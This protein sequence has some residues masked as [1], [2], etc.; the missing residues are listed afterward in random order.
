MLLDNG[1]SPNEAD[2]EGVTPAL[3]AKAKVRD[4]A[5]RMLLK[6]GACAS[7]AIPERVHTSASV[8]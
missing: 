5:M 7:N 3:V 8:L 2:P 4:E 6:A 1:A